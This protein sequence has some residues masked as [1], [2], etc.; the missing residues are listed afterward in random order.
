MTIYNYIKSKFHN[1]KNKINIQKAQEWLSNNINKVSA[2][3]EDIK[4]RD[5]IFEP[6]KEVFYYPDKTL[7]KDIYNVITQVAIINAILAGLPGQLGVGVY[8]SIAFE[9]WMGYVIARHVGISILRPTEIFKYIGIIG[10]GLFIF[11]TILSFSFS[12]FS[13][14]PL[15]PLILAEIFT[16]NLI[17][18]AFW[19]GFEEVKKS[20]SFKIPK[21]LWFEIFNKSKNLYIHQ[22]N[23][24]KNTFN[25]ENLKKVANR[26]KMWLNGDIYDTKEVRGEIFASAAMAYLLSGHYDK[27]QG[28]LGK[29]F[30]E[31]I[32]LRWSSQFDENTPI[33]EIAKRF[34]EYSPEQ[35]EGAINT[36]KGKMF[37][38]LVTDLEN[39]DNDDIKAH[40]FTNES[41]PDSDIIF[42]NTDTGEK[43]ALS[44]KATH[45]PEIIEHALL[46]YPDTPILTTKEIS[47]Y[48]EHNPEYAH[49]VFGTDISNEMLENITKENV[50]KLI[51]SIEPV[52][53]T[54]V[55]VSGVTMSSVALVWPLLMAYHKKKITYP[56]FEKA[57]K[58]IFQKQGVRLA[59]RLAYGIMFGPLFAWYLLARS[60][61]LISNKAM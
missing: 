13:I 60:I 28:P 49:K 4:L 30:E 26:L 61:K 41:H 59:S 22:L 37:E 9:A 11:K 48:F 5:F 33:E 23:I 44:L 18:I 38:I 24:L 31:A 6:F 16:T 40:M 19:V 25:T 55:V 47:D 3:F 8:V 46:K 21:R 27:L 35:L 50:D 1:Y 7:D 20:G 43:I 34:S 56:Q 10:G 51:D 53:E 39:S 29:I 32:R 52:N 58:K 36:I 42:T 57:M 12:L 2:L 17:G 15:N 54:E 14:I 45:N